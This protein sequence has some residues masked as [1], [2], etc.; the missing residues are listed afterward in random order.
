MSRRLLERTFRVG[1]LRVGRGAGERV[2][3]W[4]VARVHEINTLSVARE[5]AERTRRYERRNPVVRAFCGER[6][7]NG[8]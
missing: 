7:A 6:R 4:A 2:N 5:L 1:S 8:R 3:E